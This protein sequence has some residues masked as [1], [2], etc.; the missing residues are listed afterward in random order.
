MSFCI[1]H[2][3]KNFLFS[4][5]EFLKINSNT[6]EKFLDFFIFS[7]SSQIGKIGFK[8][9]LLSKKIF[10]SLEKFFKSEKKSYSILLSSKI[11]INSLNK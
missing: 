7:K 8:N 1:S 6:S 3:N 9:K 4:H 10:F 5:F 11:F 2:V